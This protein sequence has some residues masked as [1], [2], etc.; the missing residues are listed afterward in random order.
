[1]KR[2]RK[3]KKVL[4]QIPT[5]IAALDVA[6]SARDEFLEEEEEEGYLDEEGEEFFDEGMEGAPEQE[7]FVVRGDG[8]FIKTGGE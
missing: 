3:R 6:E 5:Q 2:A 4:I 7:T 8:S 1:M